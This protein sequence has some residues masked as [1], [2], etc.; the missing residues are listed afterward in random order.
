MCSAAMVLTCRSS[1]AATASSTLT[2][3]GAGAGAAWAAVLMIRILV[4]DRTVA[5]RAHRLICTIDG[6]FHRGAS[7]WVVLT[8]SNA[9]KVVYR[10]TSQR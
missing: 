2:P 6:L 9:K 4:A 3:T 8:I 10:L 7:L 5:T 1:L